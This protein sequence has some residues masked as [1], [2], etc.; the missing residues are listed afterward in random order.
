MD[1]TIIMVAEVSCSSFS[2]VQLDWYA[3]NSA[4]INCINRV[5]DAAPN[6]KTM[7]NTLKHQTK[8]G[9]HYLPSIIVGAA[10]APAVGT[11]PAPLLS[12]K[13]MFF[14]PQRRSIESI[15]SNSLIN[16]Y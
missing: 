5:L 7:N 3:G 2:S 6:W 14:L 1:Y 16:I 13:V 11:L 8:V 9:A 4:Y 10:R 12:A 15:V